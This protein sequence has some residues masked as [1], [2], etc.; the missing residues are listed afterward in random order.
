MYQPYKTHLGHHEHRFPFLPF[1]AGLAISPFIYGP[2][3]FYP[4]YYPTPYYGPYPYY[5]GYPYGGY[6]GKKF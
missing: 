2:R 3:P 4:Y 5:G 1:L 6:Y